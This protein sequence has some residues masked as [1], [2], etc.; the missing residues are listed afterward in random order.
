MPP[1]VRVTTMGR[2][3]GTTYLLHLERPL[4][5]AHAATSVSANSDSRLP[6]ILPPLPLT[7]ESSVG[8]NRKAE[9]Q[10]EGQG[11][12]MPGHGV[13]N[14]SPVGQR[15]SAASASRASAAIS[16]SP[17][18]SSLLVLKTRITPVDAAGSKYT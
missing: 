6:D 11:R 12:P 3:R 17:A 8:G 2:V 5:P 13:Q 7:F 16:E 18:P 10:E 4:S 1:S 14:F 9:V 15:R